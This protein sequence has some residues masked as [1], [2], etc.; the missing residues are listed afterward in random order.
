MKRRLSGFTIIELTVAIVVIGILVGIT[1][2]SYSVVQNKAR[3]SALITTA[4]DVERAL[5]QTMNKLNTESWP[6]DRAFTGNENPWLNVVTESS[7]TPTTDAA[8]YLREA[9]PRGIQTSGMSNLRWTYD[10]DSE[11]TDGV[12]SPSTCDL[13]WSGVVIGIS[14][15]SKE[16][17]EQ[18]DKAYDDGNLTCGR[19][20]HGSTTLL[21][22]LSWNQQLQ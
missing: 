4:R 10:N 16:I 6:D 1:A 8:T 3:A 13:T 19:I 20:R 21:Y 5:R 7:F 9:L 15:V 12:R 14:P 17:A 11:G 22:Q 18:A 2:L